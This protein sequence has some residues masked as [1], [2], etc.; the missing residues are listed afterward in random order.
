[1][2]GESAALKRTIIFNSAARL[3]ND[4]QSP[5]GQQHWLERLDRWW[6]HWLSGIVGPDILATHPRLLEVGVSHG[7]VG[8]AAVDAARRSTP[9][10][11]ETQRR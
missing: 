5:I 11:N 2:K 7:K 4:G 6:Q 3:A 8:T 10:R 1:M 9:P